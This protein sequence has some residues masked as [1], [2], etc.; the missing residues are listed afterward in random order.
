MHKPR[1]FLLKPLLKPIQFSRVKQS[2]ANLEILQLIPNYPTAFWISAVAAVV[3]VGIAKAGFGGGVGGVATPLMA[4]TISVAD[5]AALMLPLLIICD[6]F[7]VKHYRGH[8]HRRSVGLLFSGSVAGVA[9][10]A[11]F[12]GYFSGNERM[13]QIG[14]GVLALVFVA[15]QLLRAVLTGLLQARH[16]HAAEGVLM[17]VVSGFTSTL[18]HAGG[19]PVSIFLLPQRLP[20]QLFVGTTVV[21]F[22]SL[23]LIKLVPYYQLDLLRLGNLATTLVL[24]PLCYVGVK[25][26]IYLNGRFNDLWFNRVVYG[27][28]GITGVQL[29]IG[30]AWF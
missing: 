14:I 24:A 20:R 2:L 6:F 8:F 27:V 15:F 21:F 25:L 17:G 18:A 22:A 10:G 29:V 13:L 26:G 9:L 12:F 19:P 11:W 3:M 30:R 7:S 23:N 28:L 5:A 16:P 1:G 4:L